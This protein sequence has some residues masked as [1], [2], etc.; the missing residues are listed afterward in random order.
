MTLNDEVLRIRNK[1][2][3]KPSPNDEP[4]AVWKSKDHY[5]G[6]TVDTL[7]VI[8]KTSGC[9]WGKIGGCTMCGFVY[10]SACSPPEPSDIIK[11][12]EKA[13]QK[14][15][16]LEHF[17]L[18]IFT[19][20]SFLDTGEVSEQVRGMVLDRLEKDDRI[21]KVIV[22]SRPEFVTDKDLKDCIKHLQ[23]TEFE[24][25]VGLETSSDNIRSNSINKGFK[26]KDFT[27]AADIAKDN[28]VGMKTYLLLKPPFISEGE[29]LEDLVRTIDDA[30]PYSQT[31]SIN[32]C[33]VQRGTYVEHLFQRGQYRPPW[34]WSIVEILKRAK[35]TH[36]DLVITSDPVG[37]GSKRGPHNCKRCSRDVAQAIRDF[38]LNQ[39]IRILDTV[40]CDCRQLWE[41]VIEM[42][43]LTYGSPIL[44]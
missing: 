30:A 8:F 35:H 21:F 27:T 18:K 6:K 41:K 32:L 42:D 1:Q 25:A 43:G 15:N 4:A 24:V 31:I 39:D 37:A 28:G 17:M 29:G 3:I 10:D 22:E 26:F 44:D 23:G 34:L 38:S 16:V 13:L 40:G 19:S 11:Q 12:L 7:T 36:S 2:R 9:W 33:N 20:G 5:Q 14:G